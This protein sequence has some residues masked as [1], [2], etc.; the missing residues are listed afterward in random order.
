VNGPFFLYVFFSILPSNRL[1]ENI[2]FG[3][4]LKNAQM[5][6]AR[7]RSVVSHEWLAL[8]LKHESPFVYVMGY[9]FVIPDLIRDPEAIENT[10]FR[11]SPE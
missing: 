1:R 11:L 6:G 9:L 7:N 8:F 3:R 4:G 10:G 2:V 5:Q